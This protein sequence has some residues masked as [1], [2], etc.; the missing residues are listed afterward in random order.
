M[1][2]LKHVRMQR[3]A[4]LLHESFLTVK[5]VAFESGAGDLSHFVREFKKHYSRTP[6]EFRLYARLISEGSSNGNLVA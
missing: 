4:K 1:R 6:S 2:Y 3:A 5:E